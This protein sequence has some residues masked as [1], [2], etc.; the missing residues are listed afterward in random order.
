M[1]PHEIHV[2]KWPERDVLLVARLVQLF[3]AFIMYAGLR[4]MWMNSPF[5]VAL[6]HARVRARLWWWGVRLKY[7]WR[8]RR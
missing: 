3:A 4:I 1:I 7:W 8:S 5:W 6:L 2:D